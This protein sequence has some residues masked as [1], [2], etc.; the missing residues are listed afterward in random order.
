MPGL[1]ARLAPQFEVI[2]PGQSAPVKIETRGRLQP[3]PAASDGP[4]MSI[5]GG[6]VM[7]E[8]GGRAAGLIPSDD[9]LRLA[10]AWTIGLDTMARA[11][12]AA[13]TAAA[14]TQLRSMMAEA[15][16]G[17]FADWV[18]VD[19]LTSPPRRAV[20]AREA[21]PALV[22]ALG[23]ITPQSCPVISSAVSRCTPEVRAS[24][25]DE[26]MLGGLPDGRPV[27]RV[28]GARSVAVG[29]ILAGDGACG[30]ITVVR[31][32]VGPRLGFRELGLVAQIGRLAGAAAERLRTVP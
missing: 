4:V 30:A 28:I 13:V 6:P 12:I 19:F 20:S 10:T 3:W 14:E 7:N 16:S 18:F 29:P 21:D 5:T 25:D 1:S 2:L 15:L 31:G 32:R 22:A 17:K 11:A 27:T 24:I 8:P 23:E 9:L 26:W